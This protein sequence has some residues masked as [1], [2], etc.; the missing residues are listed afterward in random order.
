MPSG[1]VLTVNSL[2]DN[3]TDTSH[4][5]LR[6]AITLVNNGGNPGSLGQSSMPPGWAAQITGSFGGDAT[7]EFAASLSGGTITLGGTSLPTITSNVTITGLGASAL[8]ISGN[9][10]SADF[11]ISS[12]TVAISGLTIEGGT[13]TFGGGL[14]S[15]GS[16]T[17]L[18]ISNATFSNNSAAYGGAL[19]T[20]DGTV[21]L[22]NDTFAD[23][24]AS[25]WSGAIDNWAGGTVYVS[26]GTFTGNSAGDGGAIGNE[27][28]TFFV[29]GAGF[30]AN[31]AS[32][33]GGAIAN[34]GS[35][36]VD[37]S[38]FADSSCKGCGGAIDAEYSTAGLGNPTITV[39]NSTLAANK[40][41]YSGAISNGIG[42]T[43]IANSTIFGNS[44][45]GS[46]GALYGLNLVT[47]SGDIVAG[48]INNS[49]SAA[50]PDDI[51]STSSVNPS[52]SDNLIGTGGSG[53]LVNGASGNQVGVALV[54]VGLAPLGDYGG[55]TQTFALLPGSFA[56]GKGSVATS[57][58]TDQRGVA[59]PVG[60]ASDVGAFQSLGFTLTK[61]GDNRTAPVNTLFNDLQ[62]T[63]SANDPGVPVAGGV[64]TFTAN[65]AAN[66][67]SAVLGTPSVSLPASGLAST[68][69]IANGLDGTYTVTAA[70]GG[71][72]V[73]TFTLTNTGHDAFTLLPGTLPAWTVNLPGYNQTITAAGGTAP[74]TFTT[75]AGTLPTGLMLSSS[76]VLSGT[77]TVAGSF[78]FTVMASDSTS[79]ESSQT[80]TLT[81]SPPVAI[82]NSTL[83]NWPANQ[84]GYN[85]T[86]STT[87]GTGTTTFATTT[88]TLPTG[89]TLSSSGVLSGTP[90]AAGSYT[91]TVTATDAVGASASQSYTVS[92]FGFSPF[93]LPGW[94]V[95]RP[96]YSQVI[97]ASGGTGPYTFSATGTLPPGLTLSS[98]G[99]L[100]GVP[101]AAGVYSFII[102]ATDS[103]GVSVSKSDSVTINPVP[104]LSATLSDWTVNQPGYSQ[105]IGVSGGTAPLTFAQTGGTLPT[106][107]SLSSAGVLAGTPTTVGSSTFTVTATD[108]AGASASQS[109]T[110]LINTSVMI[111]TTTLANGSVGQAGYSQTI[112]ATG[113]TVPALTGFSGGTG[114]TALTTDSAPGPIFPSSNLLQITYA[115]VGQTNA[116]WYDTPVL[117]DNAFTVKFTYQDLTPG[118]G[119]ADGMAF[120]L[121]SSPAGLSAIG[122][123][124]GGSN[125]GYLLGDVTPSAA[126]ELNIWNGHTQGGAFDSNASNTANVYTN[127][128]APW[129]T[130][131]NGDPINFT[132]TYDGNVKAVATAVD[133]VTGAS[134][135]LTRTLPAGGLA[136]ILGSA[137][138]TYLGFTGATGAAVATQFISNFFFQPALASGPYTFSQTAGT[139]PPGL[140]LSSS[141]VLSGTPTPAGSYTF[142]VS[143]T[144]TA[145]ASASQSYTVYIFGFS[146]AVLPGWTVNQPGYNQTITVSGGTGPYTFSAMGTLP[147]GLTLSSGGV[148]SG[149]PTAVSTYSF[150]VTATDSG[151]VSASK[152]ETVII[153][154][155]P[156]LSR[157][158]TTLASFDSANGAYPVAGLIE[159]SS[160]N[161]FGTTLQG[162]S[163]FDGTVFEILQG[164]GTVTTL[165]NF[166]G[167]NGR[168]PQGGL[169]L[170][171]SGNLFGTT[172]YGGTDDDGTVFEILQGSGSVTT[173]A[174]FNVANGAYPEAG[175]ALDSS[176]N[177][178]GTTAGGGTAGDGTVFEVLHASGTVSTLGSFNQSNGVYLEAGVAL[179][180]SGNLFGTTDPGGTSGYGTVFEVVKGSGSVTTLA[181]FNNTN[182]AYPVGDLALDTSGN[183]FGNT[184]VGGTYGDGTV[185]E[186][187]KGSGSVTTLAN[188]NDTSGSPEAGLIED[189]SGNLFGTT[190]AGPSFDGTVF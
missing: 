12:A 176:G 130:L 108:S 51:S 184:D 132:I 175:L 104:V 172:E 32:N 156:V 4:L 116:V 119:G 163:S 112:S 124:S 68:M 2:A 22:N 67:A 137:R 117:P 182:G 71:S 52:S 70:A 133:T 74:Y 179:D 123:N 162:G 15:G 80:Y 6:D 185:F 37:S 66:G 83:A 63:V 101:T 11:N 170:D 35:L 39:T 30:D 50:T 55:A 102:T 41:E 166:N 174:N 158:L 13:A 153:D 136:G 180:S 118:I 78:S 138:P 58:S 8:A 186:V 99:V 89:L 111:A 135:S 143:A 20:R 126:L 42:V 167:T 53:G 100:S 85:Q 105:T 164:S 40:A 187:V 65:P 181:N 36:T 106:G 18:T 57:P 183:L 121:Q 113:G 129:G 72:N 168:D 125:L 120:V 64:L 173:L 95:N 75:T 16:A 69:A 88:G 152:S 43:S 146:P 114:W 122:S 127:P 1:T 189:S 59:R 77:P 5:T 150:S 17:N 97:T 62:G 19:Y 79:G 171:S 49:G 26:G 14:F 190:T 142:T 131:W 144:D 154:P 107:L 84:A 159:D 87:G 3:T 61:S 134:A 91:F 98:G 147:P 90:T 94:T 169:A 45:S 149:V 56:L 23:N 38:T 25:A 165:V 33:N 7:I 31:T 96:G 86:I 93:V 128:G 24:T 81:M 47:L 177:L 141:G 140:T 139:L 115:N 48:N 161:L 44:A 27:W 54:D 160:G 73:T 82:T 103:T 151:G 178:F 46:G 109:Y 60:S 9:S 28:G 155:D 145:G 92:I 157:T 10:Q 148:L 29:T 76:G 110:V 21:T 188:F 34:D